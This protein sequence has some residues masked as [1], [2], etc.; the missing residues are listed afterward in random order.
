MKRPYYRVTQQILTVLT[1]FV[2]ISS[3]YFQYVKG[4]Q[5]CPLCFM[6]RVCAC[7]LLFFCLMGLLLRSMQRAKYVAF[8]QAFFAGAGLYFAL[9]Q[10]WLQ[11]GTSADGA[12]CLPGLEMLIRYF[13]WR[14]IV[15]VFFWG[16]NACAEVT[17][18]GLGLSIAALSALYFLVVMGLSG[19]VLIQLC[20]RTS[21]P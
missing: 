5:P 21:L 6:Q 7:V 20:R 17:W 3:F 11:S 9:R 12:V 15:N 16:S 10:L 2:I 19:F 14:A 4:F 1:L 18:Y 13:P 8:F